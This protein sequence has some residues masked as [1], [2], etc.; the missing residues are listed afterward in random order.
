[1]DNLPVQ[2]Y[3]N[4][5][6]GIA[7]P[8]SL[9]FN[10]SPHTPPLPVVDAYSKDNDTSKHTVRTLTLF[11]VAIIF[12]VSAMSF[13]LYKA[14]THTGD[15]GTN[16]ARTQS[17]DADSNTEQAKQPFLIQG[18]STS[19]LQIVAP[20]GN[21]ILS[22]DAPTTNSK[23][24]IPNA[25]GTI[26]LDINNCD[27]ATSDQLQASTNDIQTSIAAQ[28]R[29]VSSRIVVQGGSTAPTALT[30]LVLSGLEICNTSGCK[31]Q[32]SSE[33]YIQSGT[34][35]QSGNLFLQAATANSIAAILQANANGNGDILR[36]LAGNG[37]QVM[38]VGS[39]GGTIFR[40]TTDST[41][42]F[43]VQNSSGTAVLSVSSINNRVSIDASFS[44]LSSPGALTISTTPTGGALAANTYYYV[45]TALDG[46][47]GQT[48]PSPESSITTT[49]T[50][51]TVTVS[52]TS[53]PGASSYRIY[54]GV[55]SG[56]Q[57]QY[58]NSIGTLSG[59]TIS[60]VDNGSVNN[61]VGAVPPT[62]NT[63]YLSTNNA[64]NN[65][66]LVVGGN[67]TPTSQLYV[68]G[69]I[70]T[71]YIGATN[72]TLSF[73]RGVVAA[74]NY[75]YV[76]D[77]NGFHVFDTS[78][79][80]SPTSISHL[81]LSAI[82][83]SI[84][85]NG[86]YAYVGS[87]TNPANLYI[88]DVSNPTSPTI[89]STSITGVNIISSL[90][91]NGNYLYTFSTGSQAK[92]FDVSK[93]TS[94]VQV[95]A[96][97]MY[98]ASSIAQGRYIYTVNPNGSQF[99]IVDTANQVAPVVVGQTSSGLSYPLNVSVVGRYAYV[100]SGTGG[101]T[102]IDVS[103]PA[104]PTTISTITNGL[105]SSGT[106]AGKALV[107]QGR[108]VYIADRLSARLAVFDVSNPND[109][110]FVG[111]TG[112]VAL[113]NTLAINGRYAYSTGQ[114]AS[115]AIFDL[116]GAYVQQFQSGGA[117]IGTLAVDGSQSIGGD[118]SLQGSLTV[119]SNTVLNGNL[120][121]SGNAILQGSLSLGNGILG[122]LTLTQI[123]R[124]PAPSLNRVGAAGS[125]SYSYAVAAI[126]ASGGSTLASV[127][128][129]I[130]NANATLSAT[131]YVTIGWNA[132][133]GAVGYNIYR[134]SSAGTPN[135]TGL[136]GT[137]TFTGFSDTGIAATTPAPSS[138]TSGQL[139]VNGVATFK[140]T[141]NTTNAF[142]VQNASGSAIL[143]VDTTNT[144][145]RVTG[146]LSALHFIGASGT[147]TIT[148]GGGAGTSP[149]ISVLGNDSAGEIT[150]TTG[151]TPGSSTIITTM[152]FN[153]AYTS[154]PYVTFSPANANAA[155]LSGPTNIFITSSVNGFTLNAGT[156]GLAAGT[157]YKWTYQVIQ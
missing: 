91:L 60:F 52:W 56:G 155:L 27:Y 7:H 35:A 47:G 9:D 107:V 34:S 123:A 12:C 83:N 16:N 133:P 80:V 22:F 36:L 41:S 79:P 3:Q 85:V 126:G 157:Q 127:P 94:P 26:C 98:G 54:R 145:V 55:S 24:I 132:I 66:Q 96:G 153:A 142:L 21:T 38:S 150:L 154:A 93:P 76:I 30:T 82:P 5:G 146:N 92:V 74:N 71:T 156:T 57:T 6:D 13:G 68:S 90:T 124:P 106:N 110:R 139:N 40:N 102:I 130:T 75:L 20:R 134:T 53:V 59:S 78:N 109:P 63:A 122:G 14:I 100:V 129:T 58:Y 117:Q 72:A 31:S 51:S 64:S 84:I 97:T 105:N 136:I 29:G 112:G 103:N 73:P 114:F 101:L 143:T 116:G 115:L 61:F 8:Q 45:V 69:V 48:T 137:T 87:S 108:Y 135:S 88:I 120:G 11:I 1:M 10:A 99:Q 32:P 33:Q 15:A 77:N 151:G 144:I 128:A 65:T 25:N 23:V 89:V 70:P 39:T 86:R 42:A 19:Q 131:N 50:T 37:Q 67:G 44:P 62:I 113:L 4:S 149:T 140:N 147:P 18:S 111:A 95:G 17:T 138:D 141:S 49:G 148:A 125:T 46:A 81:T 104:T 121:V 28:I 152:T 2:P 119:G 118:S 43:Q